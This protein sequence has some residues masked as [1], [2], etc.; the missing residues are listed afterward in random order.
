MQV[1]VEA[2]GKGIPAGT[3]ILLAG[4]IKAPIPE[5]VQQEVQVLC[6]V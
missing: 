4:Q 6:P 1:A 5:V 2:F 3:P